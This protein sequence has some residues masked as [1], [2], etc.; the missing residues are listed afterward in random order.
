MTQEQALDILKT[1]RNVF[2][3][4]QAGSGKTYVINQYIDYLHQHKINVAIT[5]STGIAATHIGGSTIHSWSGMG[6]KDDLSQSQ[7]AKLKSRKYLKSRY[8]Q[9]KVLI[10]DEISMLHRKQFELLDELLKY[11]KSEPYKPFGGVQIVLSGD[12]LQLPPVSKINEPM[13]RRYSFMS[14]SFVEAGFIICYLHTQYRQSE[15][16]LMAILNEIRN[17][18]FT[19]TTY[20]TLQ[21]K[22][23]QF[24]PGDELHTTRLYTHNVDVDKVNKKFNNSLTSKEKTYKAKT[25]GKKAVIDKFENYSLISF[26]L[27]IKLGARVM[28]I[29]NDQEGN[30][31]NGTVGEV[32]DFSKDGYPLITSDQGKEIE[33]K[34]D[35][36]TVEDEKGSVIA[37]ISQVP[38]RLAWAVTV[39][40]SQG[41]TLDGAEIDLSKT[42][43]PGQGYV[44]ISRIRSLD[45]LKLKGINN[46]ALQLDRLAFKADQRFIE[47]SRDAETM[48]NQEELKTEQKS[49][50]L[51]AEGDLK[52]KKSKKKGKKLNT[53]QKTKQLL[54]EQMS[55]KEI[56][57][58]RSLS[59]NTI[60][61]HIVKISLEDRNLNIDYL[62]PEEDILRSVTSAVMDLF[63]TAEDRKNFSLKEVYEHLQ[64]RI[65]YEDIRLALVFIE[66]EN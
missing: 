27:T 6:I 20:T 58:F 5:A 47:L 13:H 11:M 40:K 25:E 32:T 38:L 22:V 46:R 50:I 37:K 61:K 34:P 16:E 3:T 48:F 56:A 55:I 63:P 18:D 29:K 41:M 23:Q 44:A 62:R 7:M 65:T 21:E 59:K 14:P 45:G 57:E 33:A 36:W 64:E 49:F 31:M 39:H 19:Q 60:V 35:D 30:Y 43:E 54:E 24:T 26:Q 66:R 9:V 10:L 17:Q 28:F 1:G 15:N 4:G 2:L 8:N 53:Y 42:F 51:L 52:G 12:F